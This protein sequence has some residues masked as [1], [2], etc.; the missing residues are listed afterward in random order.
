MIIFGDFET[1]SFWKESEWA[2]RDITE[3]APGNDLIASVEAELGYK[4]P[5]TYIELAMSRNGGCPINPCHPAPSRTSWAQDHVAISNIKAIG[6]SKIWSLCG[7]LGQ[8]NAV[9]EWQYPPIGVYFG[10]CPSAGHDRIALDYRACGPEGEP[11]VVHVDQDYDYRITL[12]APNF[13]SFIRSLK[14]EEDFPLTD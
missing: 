8:K 2:A 13:E 11:T 14:P 3:P 9:E 5:E 6:R 1:T 4:L 12:L 10:D 7:E